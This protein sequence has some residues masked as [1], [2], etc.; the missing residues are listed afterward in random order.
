MIIK[1]RLNE[2]HLFWVVVVAKWLIYAGAFHFSRGIVPGD[3]RSL[4]ARWPPSAEAPNF[5]SRLA[6]WDG[7]Y[8]LRLADQWYYPND[9][10]CAFFPAWPALLKITKLFNQLYAP[11]V[12]ALVAIVLWAIAVRLL[13]LTYFRLHGEKHA[14]GVVTWLTVLPSSV[15]F[16]LPYTES[17]FLFLA[18]I[19][20]WS[21][22]APPKDRKS[23]CGVIA[24]FLLPLCRPV[25]AFCVVF[26][27]FGMLID[28]GAFRKY[29]LYALFG[30]A[31]IGFYYALFWSMTG[32]P[33][34]GYKAQ[35]HFGNHPSL[36]H[37]LTPWNLVVK[38]FDCDQW[39]DPYRSLLDRIAFIFSICVI[40]WMRNG[41]Y[42]Q[43]TWCLLLL[44]VPAFTNWF[45][46]MNR[47]TS[48]AFP[49]AS[50][51]SHL[52]SRWA[53]KPIVMGLWSGCLFVQW[54]LLS[55]HFSFLWAN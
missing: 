41:P 10:A 49:I 50:G 46:S 9:P 20:H 34:H 52:S 22:L 43:R 38:L 6:A 23:F 17:L 18:V 53:I 25:G 55:R 44:I 24:M 40:P 12:A 32:D 26:P 21:L 47:F 51:F 36:G 39:I 13:W 2:K 4:P 48:V 7:A 8:Y 27:L 29:L 14:W 31:G 30:F 45:L 19:V 1:L 33:F 35:Q 16:W 28:R 5:W 54:Q 3:F 37:M 42:G 11:M 15:Y